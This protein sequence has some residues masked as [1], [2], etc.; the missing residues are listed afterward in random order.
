MQHEK[1]N[2]KLY[3]LAITKGRKIIPLSIS[4][5][6]SIFF[7]LPYVRFSSFCVWPI[8]ILINRF[9]PH[10][11]TPYL[12]LAIFTFIHPFSTTTSSKKFYVSTDTHTDVRKRKERLSEEEKNPRIKNAIEERRDKFMR[13]EAEAITTITIANNSDGVLFFGCKLAKWWCYYT[14]RIEERNSH[15]HAHT[16]RIRKKIK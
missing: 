2:C 4:F 6:A 5:H 8:V 16:H 1:N 7:P 13:W 11:L 12:L 9:L 14:R 15:S 3:A 10:L